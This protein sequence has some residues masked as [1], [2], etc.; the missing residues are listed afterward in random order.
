MPGWVWALCVVLSVWTAL[1]LVVVI[2]LGAAADLRDR[3]ASD[4]REHR[5]HHERDGREG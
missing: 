4:Y 3:V 2:F 1:G 5:E